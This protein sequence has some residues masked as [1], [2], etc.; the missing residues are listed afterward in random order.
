MSLAKQF[1]A[2]LGMNLA[3]IPRRLG[4]VC[5]IIIGVT[6]TV[7]VLVSMLAMGVGAHQEAM[8][9]VRPDRVILWSTGALNSG[10]STISKDTAV[11]LHDLP[12]IKRNARGEPIAV[13]QVFTFVQ[14]RNKTDGGLIGFP[15]SGVTG[16]LPDYMPEL[17]LTSGRLFKSGL[18]EVIASNKCP[19]DY[20]DFA[21]GDKRRM[22]GGDWLV[23]GS[24]DLG[25]TE[26]TC[27]VFADGETVQSAFKRDVYNEVDVMLQSP[28]AF[29]SFTRAIKANPQIKVQAKHEAEVV[30]ENSQQFNWILNFISYFV[31]GIMALAATIGAANSLYAIVDGRR[32]ELATLRA[33]GFRSLPIVASVL[34][35]SI[36]LA[37]P[38][39]LIG[40]LVAWLLCNGLH[41]SPL[42]ASFRLAVTPA[43]AALGVGWAMGIGILS[44]L[45]PAVTAARV[46][47]TVALRAT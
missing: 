7:G 41:A 30:E 23:V 20:N 21:V 34:S 4:L 10:Q 17:H 22:P 16:P 13:S 33:I 40:A 9:N 38:G 15:L 12:E 2:L 25:S 28:G 14:A 29:A 31:G 6:C 11:L 44:G 18:R 32:R 47:V 36:L 19:H 39:A 26:G 3:S 35:E 42:G 45:V 46:P 43:L 37:V 27:V 1:W 5:T 24:F 8:G